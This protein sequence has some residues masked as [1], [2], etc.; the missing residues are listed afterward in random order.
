M[1]KTLQKLVDRISELPDD[2]QERVAEMLLSTL[3]GDSEWEILLADS[4]DVLR[5]MGERAREDF[6][7]GKTEA[8]DPDLL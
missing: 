3:D 8:L 6:R 2:E 7:A 5:E 1:T 4:Q